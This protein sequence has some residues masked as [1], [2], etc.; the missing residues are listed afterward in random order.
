M[1]PLPK[2]E[3]WR[4]ISAARDAARARIG[5]VAQLGERY[6]RN[7]EVRG[8]IPLSSTIKSSRAIA[9]Q[10]APRGGPD[11]PAGRFERRLRVPRSLEHGCAPS[12]KARKLNSVYRFCAR[13]VFICRSSP[14]DAIINGLNQ[15]TSVDG[16]TVSYDSKGNVTSYDGVSFTY[17]AENF[18][19]SGNGATISYDAAGRFYQRTKT[20][21]DPRKAIYAGDRMIALYK[22]DDTVN[23]YF[24]HGAGVDDPIVRRGSSGV[25]RF[26]I[27]DE[28]GSVIASTKDD[29]SIATDNTYD[30]YGRQGDGNVGRFQYTGQQWWGDLGLYYYKARWYNP[31]LGRFMSGRPHRLW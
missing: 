20:G 18:L 5:A 21:V 16:D 27:K 23:N 3:Y 22:G 24:I 28:R 10:Y 26:L 14:T 30:S 19:T 15:A 1:T 6:V 25:R 11:Y 17:D 29:G 4:I 31:E 12:A 2:A 7:V 8:S 9:S 13:R